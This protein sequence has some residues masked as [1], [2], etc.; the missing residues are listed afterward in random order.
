V[1]FALAGETS[2]GVHDASGADTLCKA[3]S[4]ATKEKVCTTRVA[5]PRRKTR[6]GEHDASE[7]N[8]VCNAHPSCA[9]NVKVVNGVQTVSALQ[10]F[11]K[12]QSQKLTPIAI[13]Y[14]TVVTACAVARQPR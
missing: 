4:C 8:T 2:S 14:K 10:L 5:L 7:A 11:E 9:P 12:M 1:P 13:A 6:R 3:T